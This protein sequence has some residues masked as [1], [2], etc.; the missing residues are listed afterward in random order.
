[1]PSASDPAPRRIGELA[2]AA[3]VVAVLSWAAREANHLRLNYPE[4]SGISG[5][6]SGDPDGL[7]QAR[8]LARALEEGLPPAGED[9]FLN[10][11]QGAPIPWPPYYTIA[12]DGM[13]APF[14]PADAAERDAF[15]ERAVATLP[16]F[17]GIGTS[18]L[19]AVA[20]WLLGGVPAALV[21]G[22]SHALC[23]GSIHYGRAGVGDFHAWVSLLSGAMLLLVAL[24]LRSG[25][26]ERRGAAL[27]WGTAAGLVV[28]ALL[29]S[30]VGA[31]LYVLEVQVVLAWLILRD[32]RHPAAGL[33][34][35]GLSFHVA[36]LAA[37]LPAVLWSPWREEW[38]W[39]VV[40]LSWFHPAFL[41]LSAAVFLPLWRLPPWS[42]VR[43][44]YPWILIGALLALAAVLAPLGGGPI[45]GIRD[46]F[47]WVSRASEF[48]TG[49][50]ESEPLLGPDR[51]GSGGLFSW[52]GFGVLLL[53]LLV[54]AGAWQAWRRG[55]LECL[56]W[57]AAAAA[58]LPQA[59]AQRRFA[60]P[61]SL[62]MAVLLGWGFA[63]ALELV[64]QRWHRVRGGAAVPLAL[65]L[66]LVLQAPA[67]SRSADRLLHRAEDRSSASVW[68]QGAWR[69]LAEWLREREPAGAAVLASWDQ[70]HL[71]EWTARRPTVATNFGSYVGE[72]SFRDPARFF[73]A[74]QGQAAEAIL[75]RR[76]AR[77][78]LVHSALADGLDEL[79]RAAG[80]TS[81]AAVPRFQDTVLGRLSPHGPQGADLVAAG[82]RPLR[83]LR[84]VHVSPYGDPRPSRR[85]GAATVPCGWIW[86]RVPGAWLELA[87]QP[88]DELAVELQLQFPSGRTFRYRDAAPA[89]AEGRIRLRLPYCTDA[90]NGDAVVTSARWSL[91]AQSHELVVPEAA[92]LGG[93]A[94]RLG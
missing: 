40:N 73:A 41:A 10:F 45:D 70:G 48:M 81:G 91:G 9:P 57:V 59:L 33:P 14:A 90:R 15:L 37:V 13:I 38:P 23:Y 56:P 36:A 68:R 93:L 65:G 6:F 18:L 28:G 72:D 30:W 25:G 71:L 58:L 31:L 79:V 89:G 77:F 49:V 92:V 94:V 86:E 17:F 27:A 75:E 24:A 21:A 5:W 54:A 82:A 26:L 4:P 12:L 87:G 66:A 52:L 35:F 44:R 84:L 78:V 53:P 61:L 50:A 11:P 69:L 16:Q 32:V 62:P 2:A 39:M 22:G 83:F 43:R 88:G 51:T 55:A 47:A 74:T 8:R 19:A 34:A 42:P 63:R 60:D 80:A 7:Y 67:L 46:G 20:G 1:M 85:F 64:Q 29:G 76:Q 3:V